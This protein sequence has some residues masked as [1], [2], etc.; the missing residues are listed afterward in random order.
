MLRVQGE[1]MIEAGIFDGDKIIVRKQQ[2]AE[3][4]DIVVALFDPDGTE[5]GATV[6]RFFRRDGKIVLH[7]ENSALSDF[8]LDSESEAMIIGKVVGLLRKL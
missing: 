4:G 7:P 3:N 2:N 8:I 1:S 6:K 5:Q